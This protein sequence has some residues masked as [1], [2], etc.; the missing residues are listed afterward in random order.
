MKLQSIFYFIALCAVTFFSACGN[1]GDPARDA[2]VERVVVPPPGATPPPAPATPATPEPPQNAEGVWHYTCSNGCAG[3][4]G[5]AIACANCGTTLAHN[6]A[7]HANANPAAT[8]PSG[9]TAAG[10]PAIS[11]VTAPPAAEPLQNAAGVW[12]YTCSNGCEGGG[13]SATACSK[14]GSTLAHNTAYHQ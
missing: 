10:A 6:T 7:Y 2:A 8:P 13:G 14:C 3:G 9:A 12:H 11:P 1:S 4:A 5:S